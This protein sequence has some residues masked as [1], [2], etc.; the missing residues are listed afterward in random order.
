MHVLYL[1]SSGDFARAYSQIEVYLID[2]LD[3]RQ[4][5]CKIVA[6]IP[7]YLHVVRCCMYY[8]G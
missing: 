5:S 6:V 7:L 4:W 1:Q 3:D 2:R 8:G